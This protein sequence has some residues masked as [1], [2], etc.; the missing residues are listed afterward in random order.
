M[1]IRYS[2]SRLGYMIKYISNSRHPSEWSLL[3]SHA[4]EKASNNKV[5]G[6]FHVSQ[7]SLILNEENLFL[8]CCDVT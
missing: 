7:N 5:H 6:N 1:E 8:E 3:K 2:D 4:Q